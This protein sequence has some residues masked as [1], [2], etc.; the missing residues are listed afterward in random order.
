MPVTEEVISRLE[1]EIPDYNHQPLTLHHLE[2]LASEEGFDLVVQPLPVDGLHV[3]PE[4]GRGRVIL[5]NSRLMPGHR[6]FVGWHEYF[7]KLHPGEPSYYRRGGYFDSKNELQAS[8][9][10]AVA[11]MP[12]PVLM[13]IGHEAS[14]LDTGVLRGHFEVPNHLARFRLKV[15]DGYQN[16]LRARRGWL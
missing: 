10:A 9:L 12:T 3:P 1:T 16:L 11:V 4:D 6:D 14:F 13:R 5:V 2:A 7:H 15:L 8:I